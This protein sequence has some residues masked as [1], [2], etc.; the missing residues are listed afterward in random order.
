MDAQI[1]LGQIYSADY[2][3]LYNKA[4]AYKWLGIA[5]QLGNMNAAVARE[6]L[7]ERLTAG[8][9]IEFDGMVNIWMENHAGM[10]ASDQD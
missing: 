9:V 4:E 6:Q 5:T 10:V 3:P 1:G 8:E 2:S 7:A